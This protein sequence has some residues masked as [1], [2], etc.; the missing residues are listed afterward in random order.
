MAKRKLKNVDA[1]LQIARAKAIMWGLIVG[2]V[3]GI[4]VGVFV[5][6]TTGNVLLGILMGPV[7]CGGGVTFGSQWLTQ[8]TAD[9]IQQIHAPSGD[10]TPHKHEY[11]YEKSLVARGRYEEALAAFAERYGY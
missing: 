1:A 6:G 3:L 5:I 4:P 10:S 7:F 9:M 2:L 8:R 11:S